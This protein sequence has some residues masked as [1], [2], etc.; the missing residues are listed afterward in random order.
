MRRIEVTL[1]GNGVFHFKLADEKDSALFSQKATTIEQA[2]SIACS[3]A[4]LADADVVC[5]DSTKR[6]TQ[7]TICPYC[8]KDVPLKTCSDGDGSEC[9]YCGG[10][11]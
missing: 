8:H 3:L 1:K 11:D 2:K 4:R 6:K 7:S 9:S 10:P 5:H